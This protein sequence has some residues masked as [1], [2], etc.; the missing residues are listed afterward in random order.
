MIHLLIPMSGQ[1][2]RY[3]KA[4]Y[5]VPKPLVP[6]SGRTMI[7]RVLEN[8]PLDWPC[9][10]VM[11][12]NHL[13]TELPQE[14]RRLRPNAHV[15]A[16]PVHS[17]GPL[18]AIEKGLEFIPDDEPVLVNYCDY[19]MVWDAKQFER[20]V[21]QTKCDACL[22]SYIGFHAHYLNP[23]TYAYS[24]LK[25]ERVVEV[26]EKGSFT[27]NREAEYASSG[28]YYFKSA[29]LL[30]EAIKFQREKDIR[31]NGEFYTSLTVQAL[32]QMKPNA[33]VRVFEIPGFF[34]W[35]TPQ[36]L[37]RFEYWE[38]T[39]TNFNLS[40]GDS[41]KTVGQVLMPMAGLGSRFKEHT[42]YPKPFIPVD[43]KP[44][45]LRALETLPKA[46]KKTVI[47]GLESFKDLLEKFNFPKLEKKL[48]KATPPG[49][50][51]STS[52]GV[53]QLV[54]NSDIVV[55]SCD[56]GIVLFEDKW[57]AFRAAP[58]C[59]AAIF[60]IS[61]F[62]GAKEKPTSFAYVVP[63][64]KNV[65]IFPTVS[66]VSVKKPVSENPD[67]DHLLV[68][69][70]WFRDS[71]VIRDGIKQ[72]IEKDIRVNNELYLD[73]VFELLKSQGMKVRMIPLDGY[74][75][76]GDPASLAEALYWY[77]IFCGRKVDKRSRY[78]GIKEQYS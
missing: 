35:G 64:E 36:D 42:E 62:P 6:V 11:A 54:P 27:N 14:L 78:P 2:T 5:N 41:P 19:G 76:W 24:R 63:D 61:G 69:T 9:T 45:F 7:E 58:D 47:V 70:F 38:K 21:E 67:R 71:N 10:F 55:S 75:N 48:L 74:I 77:E 30:R 12:E 23:Q 66:Y 57:R 13:K 18:K 73:S 25:G 59:D 32:L 33:H 1:G 46:E 65:H 3:H 28:G 49:Q 52:E 39:F 56:H 60:T 16:V 50:A 8:F 31:V 44:M 68:G 40:Q 72:L 34:Q 15:N 22:I 51:L 43:G 37:W 26:K 4:G 17:E 53:S 20:F 29:K